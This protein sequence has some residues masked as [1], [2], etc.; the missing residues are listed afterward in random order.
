MLSSHS[1]VVFFLLAS[2]SLTSSSASGQQQQE[3]QQPQQRNVIPQDDFHNNESNPFRSRGGGSPSFA[4]HE[5]SGR[6]KKKKM[7]I[8][9]VSF[10]AYGH[11]MP[12]K[13]IVEPLLARGHQV[14]LFVETPS[15]CDT[16][17]TH[18]TTGEPLAYHCVVLPPSHTFQKE[19]FEILSSIDELT[20]T[21]NRVFEEMLRHHREQL[22]NY[23][24]AFEDLHRGGKSG[25]Q[26]HLPVDLI[27]TDAS[28][29][30]G[31]SLSAQFHV[32]YVSVFPLTMLHHVGPATFLPAMGTT[33]PVEMSLRQRL[34][35]HFLN[36]A[37]VVVGPWIVQEMQHT[38][39]SYGVP[40]S[41]SLLT[42][43]Q[44]M[45]G[46]IFAPTI[47]GL[48]IAQ[49]LCPNIVPLGAFSPSVAHTPMEA[50]LE[51]FLNSERCQ[52]HGA[53]Y[54]NFGTLAV[55]NNATFERV[56]A[57]LEQLSPCCVVWKVVEA[58]R[59]A[60]F[61]AQVDDPTRYFVAPRFA[62]PIAIM[63]HNATR[64]FLTHCGDTSVL[65]A[66][67]AHLPLAGIPYFADQGDVCQRLH[68]AGIGEYVGHKHRFT[69][70]RLS[71]VLRRV[72]WTASYKQRVAELHQLSKGLG[73]ASR[74]ADMIET[75]FDAGLLQDGG[76]AEQDLPLACPHVLQPP[77]LVHEL[78]LYAMWLGIGLAFWWLVARGVQRIASALLWRM[79]K[80]TRQE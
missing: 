22:G 19:M 16:S 5:E 17:L 73:G 45:R 40:P 23:V 41:M 38:D 71:S 77:L 35:N 59:R 58:H 25:T 80:Q 15:W 54:V 31:F 56:Q 21:F 20:D 29:F 63:R 79:P 43:L 75:Y 66:V 4:F 30:V 78:D 46:L 44:G 53:V 2:F 27:V 1:V 32:P 64:V 24:A 69:V 39:R 34:F 67:Q 28:T 55:V 74:A 62:N 65:E 8:V 68:E 37:I 36:V 76:E 26:Q 70:E 18:P 7:H 13:A 9:A 57:A 12:V 52:E 6:T 60:A 51:D 49:P 47:W 10:P 72:G 14:S 3:Q 33:Y 61:A 48:D 11:F 50:D 42:E